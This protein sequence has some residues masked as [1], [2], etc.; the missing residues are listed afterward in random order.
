MAVDTV[1][2]VP[3][4][5]VEQLVESVDHARVRVHSLVAAATT[6]DERARFL[7]AEQARLDEEALALAARTTE[8][9][10]RE[11]AVADVD[12]R[13]AARQLALKIKEERLETE[14]VRLR[15]E[16]DALERR[17]ARFAVRWRWLIR[18]WRRRPRKSSL[19]ACDLLF[20]PTAEGYRLLAQQ[21]IALA[22]GSIVRGLV[23]EH[24]SFVVSKI[25]P[26]PFDGQW[27]AYLQEHESPEEGAR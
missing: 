5:D 10:E 4:A 13:I 22:P 25:A 7:A 12:A 3:L 23:G 26:W 17:E 8:L 18:T 2:H 6:L 11:A 20:V 21:G 27:C 16:R 19:R 14:A 15:A 9:A 24:R 1:T